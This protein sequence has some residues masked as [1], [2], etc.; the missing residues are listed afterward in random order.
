M[1]KKQEG[2][3]KEQ[4]KVRDLI[5]THELYNENEEEWQMLLAVYEGIK[6]IKAQGY[7]T[8]H[9]REPLAAYTR[10]ME[11]LYGLGYTKSII[12]IFHFYLFKKEPVRELKKLRD[13]ALWAMFFL[14]A[15]LYG[16]SF[17]TTI[18]DISLYAAVEGHM[19]VLVDMP[20]SQSLNRAQQI[21]NEVYPYIARYFPRAI[22]DWL[23]G[24]DQFGKPE[25][26]M[27]KLLDDNGQY[28]IW[29]KESWEVWE[30]PKDDKGAFTK[31]NEDANAIFIDGGKNEIGVV[32]FLWHYNQRSKDLGVGVSDVAEIARIDL[33]IIRNLS[34]IE[35]VVNFAA[36]PMMLK[37]KMAAD[38][39]K[40]NVSQAEDEVSVQAVQEFD[41][42]FPEA[43]PK[44]METQVAEPIASIIEFIKK[45]IE[46]IYRS[47]NAGGMAQTEISTQ[48]KSGTALKSEFQLLNSKLVGKAIN[49]EKTENKIT[50]LWLLW[51]N[52][53]PLLDDI[54]LSRERTFDIE[55]LAA[56]LENA[57]VAKTVVVS[58]TF[59]TLL[60]KNVA[61]QVL[62]TATEEEIAEIDQEI[63][64]NAKDPADEPNPQD[65]IDP[66]IDDNLNGD[67][68]VI[69]TKKDKDGTYTITRVKAEV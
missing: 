56:D 23:W 3:F 5:H 47:S 24:K 31:S 27:V 1:A 55:N 32:P 8:R 33:S 35:E 51:E 62:P 54:K 20:K 7:I 9:E 17:N 58:K 34:Q 61:R 6:Q 11:E 42:E 18:M 37:P 69:D 19:G 16:N 4:L 13:D 22:L 43:A 36:F 63:E 10:R 41:P 65:G 66:K 64:T 26:Q 60:Q 28:R 57:V 39:K 49:L 53:L 2:K 50:E 40:T 15:D 67:K 21:K 30:L 59:D 38:P 46:E 44:W 68:G 12:D 29:T 45:K 14:D 25:L 52:K 48:A